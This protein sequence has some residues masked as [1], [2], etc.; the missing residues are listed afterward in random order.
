MHA[1]RH[2]SYSIGMNKIRYGRTWT[3]KTF[4]YMY[5]VHDT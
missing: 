2:I 1:P 3:K 4:S 5:N